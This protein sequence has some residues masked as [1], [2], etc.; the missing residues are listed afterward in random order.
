M[1]DRDLQVIKGSRRYHPKK[2]RYSINNDVERGQRGRKRFAFCYV[3][4][5]WELYPPDKHNKVGKAAIHTALV[6]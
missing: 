6:A 4:E 5:Q 3:K 1:C 2:K